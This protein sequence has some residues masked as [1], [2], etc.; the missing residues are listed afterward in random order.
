MILTIS[1]LELISLVYVNILT[2]K[3]PRI[4][5]YSRAVLHAYL[6]LRG[7]TIKAPRSYT[8]RLVY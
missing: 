6:K 1:N 3:G 7:A 5:L 4:L 8:L 2:C